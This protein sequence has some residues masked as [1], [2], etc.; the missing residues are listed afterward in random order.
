[1]RKWW[2][3]IGVLVGGLVGL[4]GLLSPASAQFG[5]MPGQGMRPAMFA[6]D[7]QPQAG[8][9]FPNPA[10]KSPEAESPFSLPQDGSPNAFSG[11]QTPAHDPGY[12]FT[13]R[14]EYLHWWVTSGKLFSPLITTSTTPNL[15]NNFGALGQSST[16]ILLPPGDYDYKGINGGRAALGIAPGVIPPMEI[17]GLWFNRNLTLA[18]FSSNGSVLLARPVQLVTQPNIVGAG[19]ESVYL[20]AFPGIGG[21][22]DL[23]TSRIN[24]WG[25]DIDMLVP[26]CD[27]GTISIDFMFGYKHAELR[28]T[29]DI[30]STFASNVGQ[31]FNGQVAPAGF[32]TV[33]VDE[34]ATRNRFDGG[35]IATRWRLTYSRLTVLSDLKLSLGNTV[36]EVHISGSSLLAGQGGGIRSPG[37]ILAIPSNA[38]VTS[39]NDFTV[40][41]EVNLTLSCQLTKNVRV[42]GGYNLLYWSSVG[43]AGRQISTAIDPRQVPTDQA[44]IPGFVGTAPQFHF[45]RSDFFANG[46][47][48]G[49]EIGY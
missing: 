48:F 10:P 46:F 7:P 37:G 15:T 12:I 39:R 35:T 2:K 14:G 40:I 13:L 43:R 45:N 36:E 27:N 18:D 1:M 34:F 3:R 47:G 21:G 42:Y 30:N 22:G 19:A 33:V 44:F 17:S 38:G 8:P 9:D 31:F 20:Q 32:S 26:L 23:V 16:L 29:I 41:P 4:G 49:L 25:F 24:L 5:P 11:E 28:E 6:S